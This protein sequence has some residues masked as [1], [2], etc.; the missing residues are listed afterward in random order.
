MFGVNPVNG[1]RAKKR[2]LKKWA[3]KEQAE[4]L[5][6]GSNLDN[7]VDVWAETVLL[8]AGPFS[9]TDHEYQRAIMLEDAPRQVLKKGSQLGLSETQIFKTLYGLLTGRYSQGALYLFPTEGDVYDFSRARFNPLLIENP[10]IRAEVKDTES[11]QLKRV[12]KSMLYLRGARATSK[13]GGQKLMSTK[14]LSIPVDRVVFD[15]YDNMGEDMIEL[16]LTRMGHSSIQEEVYLGTPSIPD[17]GVSKL[18]EESD[19][20]VW[21]IKCQKCGTGTVLELEFPNCILDLGGGSVIRACRKCQGEIFPRDGQW[22]VRKPGMSKDLVGYWISRLNSTFCDL[23]KALKDFNDPSPRKKVEL[24]NSTLAMP[25]VPA[26]N[27]LQPSV[28][29]GRCGQDLPMIAHP[30]PCCMGVDVGAE[31]N[32]I[33]GFRPNEKQLQVCH[34]AR[35]T[36]F[37]E[38]NRLMERFHVKC[39]VIDMEPELRKAREFANAFPYRVFL[40]DYMDS[41]T[42]GPTWDDSKRIVKANRTETCDATHELFTSDLITLPVRSAEI[43]VFAKQACSMA[44]VLEEEPMS[45]SKNYVYRKLGDDHYRHA[46]NYLWIASKKVQVCEVDTPESRFLKLLAKK[47]NEYDPMTYGLEVAS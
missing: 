41:L 35:I 26:E 38:L 13:I 18:Y 36:D 29:Y 47:K 27:R 21:E 39:C 4:V 7:P 15:E 11:V 44:K 2:L 22:V 30:G 43:E 25:Y 23:R 6:A 14:L 46:L 17:H 12:H 45:G 40:C 16:A 31:L 32:V 28:V 42:A 10:S 20:R 3:E 9:Y 5:A 37:N 24:Y 1:W 8:P 34:L 19:Q 33:V